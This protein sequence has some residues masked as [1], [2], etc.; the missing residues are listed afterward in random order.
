MVSFKKPYELWFHI[1]LF[2]IFNFRSGSFKKLFIE[3]VILLLLF[4]VLIFWPQGT[5]GL[6]SLTRG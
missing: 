6:C 4:Y 5:W 1:V 3:F 2:F